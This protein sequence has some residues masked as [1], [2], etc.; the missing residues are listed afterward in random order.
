MRIAVLKADIEDFI[1]Y[2]LNQCILAIN[3]QANILKNVLYQ[4][5][6]FLTVDRLLSV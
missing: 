2:A 6:G 1:F 5:A 4:N 3:Q